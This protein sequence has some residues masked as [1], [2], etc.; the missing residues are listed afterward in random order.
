M[1]T[2]PRSTVMCGYTSC[3]MIEKSSCQ[4]GSIV[5]SG[6]KEIVISSQAECRIPGRCYPK[7]G[8]CMLIRKAPFIKSS[9]ITNEAHYLRRREFI[10]LATGAAIGALAGGRADAQT[11]LPNITKRMV[12]TDE[13]VN[14]FQDITSYNNYY[15][16]GT[17]KNDPQRYAGRL[18]TS[19]WTVKIDGACAKPA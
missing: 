11:P 2:Y 10:Q 6:I 1:F 16:F 3:S 14:S 4:R 15:E 18:K 19:P 9:E 8:L 7:W 12:T 17:N 5:G 13:K